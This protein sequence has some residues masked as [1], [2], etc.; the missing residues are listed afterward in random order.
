MEMGVHLRVGQELQAAAL[1]GIAQEAAEHLL[2]F[3]VERGRTVDLP[4]HHV[5]HGLGLL[6]GDLDAALSHAPKAAATCGRTQAQ[7]LRVF[8]LRLCPIWPSLSAKDCPC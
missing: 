6:G 8:L 1:G 5:V 2:G 3:I 4:A 7:R